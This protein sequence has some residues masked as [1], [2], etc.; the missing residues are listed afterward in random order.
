M[1][2]RLILSF[3]L[4]VLV[5]ITSVVVL[6]RSGAANEVRAFM[7]RG[8]MT[9]TNELVSTLEDYYLAHGSWENVEEVLHFSGKGRGMGQ[10]GMGHGGMSG[11]FHSQRLRLAGSDGT[12]IVDTSVD[13]VES[14]TQLSNSDIQKAIPLKVNSETV[15]YLLAESS[16]NFSID[17]ESFLVNRLSK[18]AFSA[19]II[20]AAFSLLLAFLLAYNLMRPVRELTQAARGLGEGN[21]STRVKVHGSDEL[22]L[23]GR[24]FNQMAASLQQAQ[25]SRKAMTADIAHELRNP[26]A[27]Q[28]A[29][30]EALQDGVI[31]LSSENF[32]VV[33]KQNLLLTQMV[34][35][36]RTLALADIGQLELES[37]PTDLNQLLER[38]V[39]AYQPNARDR[40]IT[41]S[42]ELLDPTVQSVILSVDPIRI[43]QILNNLLTNAMRFTPAGG[44]ILVSMSSEETRIN[45]SVQDSGP[46]ISTEAL[47]H[48]FDRFYRAD[49]SR[50]RS[51]GGSG[52][53]LTI[54]RYLAE[55]HRG[56]LTVSNHPGGGAIFT[57]ILPK[58]DSV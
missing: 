30:L 15:G 4:I 50:S 29:N 32:D 38:V 42:Y 18:A 49:R 3:V 51:E 23:L 5:S 58:L 6:A 28:R 11:M 48:V 7:F 31:P 10:S 26:L 52:L 34:E 22:A 8:G 33:L 21:L 14:L 55:A 47:P 43:E 24:T 41:L 19:G 57:L 35:D 37:L 20:A 56:S 39:E 1:R 45:V 25:E 40:Q 16:I 54:A 44:R 12:V 9:D 46:G 36:L 17:D 13:S 2:L 53:G 27:V